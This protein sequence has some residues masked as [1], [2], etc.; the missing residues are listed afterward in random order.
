[1]G[2]VF[3]ISLIGISIMLFYGTIFIGSIVMVIYMVI[4]RSKE[5]KVE[6]KKHKK[7]KDY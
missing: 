1:M 5:R 7:Y 6:E 4:K 3:V 2:E